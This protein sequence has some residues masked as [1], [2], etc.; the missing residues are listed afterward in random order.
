MTRLRLRV[1]DITTLN[2]PGDSTGRADLRLLDSTDV[3]RTVGGNP[4]VIKGTLVDQ[5][6]AQPLGGGQNLVAT[7]VLPDNGLASTV[8]DVCPPTSQ[9]SVD[10]Q[11]VLGVQQNG[12]FRFFVAIES[13]P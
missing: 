10:V 12:L 11:F 6:P 8:A 2:T 4:I 3:I 7:V 13:L 1:I 5:P 9:C